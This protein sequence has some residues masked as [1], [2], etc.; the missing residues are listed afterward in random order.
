MSHTYSVQDSGDFDII[1]QKRRAV[2]D[3]NQ[4]SRNVIREN[5]YSKRVTPRSVNGGVDN[6]SA[7]HIKNN[8]ERMNSSL[9]QKPRQAVYKN[10]AAAAVPSKSKKKKKAYAASE[11]I[12]R[13]KVRIKKSEPVK[14]K[15]ITVKDKNKKPFPVGLALGIVLI[16][17]VFIYVINLY[18]KIDN[19]NEDLAAINNGIAQT[20]EYQTILEVKY[21]R[22]YDLNEIEKI[23]T[24]E[25]GMVSADSLTRDYVTLTGEDIIEMVQSNE[26]TGAIGLL[27]SGF[28]ETLYKIA[29]Y[30]K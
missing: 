29:E 30:M 2:T 14:N 11:T 9:A 10:T 12:K 28:G 17:V 16:T 6:L 21:K 20:K 25:Y 3:H 22:M 27:M 13:Q 7:G 1:A 15:V 18:I 23:A 5:N 4:T 19:Y 24:E 26:N 8:I